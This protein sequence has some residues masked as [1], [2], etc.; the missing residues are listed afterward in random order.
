QRVELLE[1]LRH[2]GD[3]DHPVERAIHGRTAAGQ[4]EKRRAESLQPRL[5][6]FAGISTDVAGHVHAEE[7]ALARAEVARHLH[8]LAGKERSG[9]AIDK[10]DRA[11]LREVLDYA[12]D[13]RV[14]ARLLVA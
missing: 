8:E 5:H 9:I 4:N 13:P 6:D 3:R 1:I 10:K 12:L 7:T 11:Q 14:Q 2:H